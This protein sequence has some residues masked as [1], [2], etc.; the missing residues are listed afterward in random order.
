MTYPSLE[1]APFIALELHA[2]YSFTQYIIIS[3]YLDSFVSNL[4]QPLFG[5]Y[6]GLVF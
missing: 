1:A 6:L 2:W 4:L 5:D 3:M